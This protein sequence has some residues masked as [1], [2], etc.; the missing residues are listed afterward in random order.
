MR[1]PVIAEGALGSLGEP[2]H[3]AGKAESDQSRNSR[4]MEGN[5]LIRLERGERGRITRKVIH[6]RVELEERS[7]RIGILGA[8]L[9]GGKLG[10]L[11]ARAGHDVTFSYARS[12]RKLERLA[13][14][15]GPNARAGTPAEAAKSADI[16]LLAVPWSR[17]D[18]VLAQAGNLADKIVVTC[19][20]PMTDDDSGLAVGH[21]SSGAE[22]LAAKIPDARIVSAFSTVPSEA[23][24]GVFERKDRAP[25]PTLVYCGDD[26]GAKRKAAG[27]ISDLGFGPLDM[28]GLQ[29]ARYI[30]P[31]SLLIA[32]VAYEQEG[33][34]EV[35]YRIQ[36]A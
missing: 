9:M 5:G 14:D 6:D 34:P 24:F 32:R 7:V 2:A 4:T 21:T 20:L 18:A 35:S 17:V 12:M 33:G 13:K 8:G 15:G 31:F 16:I 1:S 10:T 26:A 25:R 3:I 28:G 30:E 27:L 36:K 29:C 19:S 23:L 11:F 22:A